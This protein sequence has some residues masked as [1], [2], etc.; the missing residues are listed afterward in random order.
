M[1]TAWPCLAACQSLQPLFKDTEDKRCC[2][3]ALKTSFPSPDLLRAPLRAQEA[4]SKE[5]QGLSHLSG[6][7][8]GHSKFVISR[9]SPQSPHPITPYPTFPSQNTKRTEVYNQSREDQ[10]TPDFG[11]RPYFQREMRYPGR[12][13]ACLLHTCST[14]V[15][16]LTLFH[17]LP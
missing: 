5:V 8:L 11:C 7:T 16:R 4:I 12:V 10:D 13:H 3:D 6:A 15:Q 17:P 14:P 1:G 2:G 9:T